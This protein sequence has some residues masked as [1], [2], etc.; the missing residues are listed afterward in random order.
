MMAFDGIVRGAVLGTY[1][2]SSPISGESG[3]DGIA[4]AAGLVFDLFVDASASPGGDGSEAS[5]FDTI[6]DAR[7]AA[8]TLFASQRRVNVAV[9]AGAYTDVVAINAGTVADPGQEVN[10]HFYF[11]GT[12]TMDGTGL[13]SVSAWDIL[14]PT[15]RVH[16]HGNDNLTISNYDGG[17][18]NG[19]STGNGTR[20]WIYDTVID[21]CADG[22][23]CHGDG[24]IYA[25]GVTVTGATKFAFAHVE[26]STYDHIDCSFESATSASGTMFAA[27]G[28]SGSLTNCTVSAPAGGVAQIAN[29]TGA[30]TIRNSRLGTPTSGAW[31][32]Y[33]Q[34]ENATIQDSYLNLQI[35]DYDGTLFD[36]CF[37]ILTVRPR[38]AADVTLSITNCVIVG[39]YR[40]NDIIFFDFLS[41][42]TEIGSS[43]TL[44]DNIFVNADLVLAARDASIATKEGF[45]NA[46]WTFDHNLFFNNT[47]NYGPNITP[48]PNDVTGQNPLLNSGTGTEAI[49]YRVGTGSPSLGAGSGGGDIG[50][51]FGEAPVVEFTYPLPSELTINGITEISVFEYRGDAADASAWVAE[52]G[53]D[54]VAAGSGGVF[55][56]ET[57]YDNI[58]AIGPEA[59]RRYTTPTQLNIGT[60]DLVVEALIF[61]PS[62]ASGFPF[63]LEDRT[64]GAGLE[65]FRNGAGGGVTV[66]INGAIN[67]TS[68]VGT[69]EWR[70]MMWFFKR[71]GSGVSYS[72]GVRDTNSQ[73]M[74]SVSGSMNSGN[75]L[76]LLS[77]TTGGGIPDGAIAHLAIWHRANW[78]DTHH[79]DSV[80][81]ERS[82]ALAAL[83][84]PG[85]TGLFG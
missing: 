17:N 31:T 38:Y 75:N 73:S 49:G 24:Y 45:M 14:H 82:A 34:I 47:T 52:A 25:K 71:D 78:L 28:T 61:I 15:V 51:G 63:Y 35:Q 5:P 43:I 12:A 16:V 18:G 6:N 11:L 44:T 19:Y 83:F 68:A 8:G 30:I 26:T 67:W 21:A 85:F 23:S 22:L 58:L 41:E 36:R 46:N 37:G 65:M 10:L 55:S 7:A 39:G 77:N 59:L 42:P 4:P 62:G 33:A 20:A 40:D 70:H 27:A 32:S 66:R 56:A 9:A 80:A 53:D 3:L 84:D 29:L 57:P 2:Y 74:A 1:D 48:G 64:S 72:Q 13:G 54:G 60:D 81:A 76:A 79:Q 69:D 50:L